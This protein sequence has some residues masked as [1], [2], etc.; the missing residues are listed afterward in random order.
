MSMSNTSGIRDTTRTPL[1]GQVAIVTGCG[2][3]D[4]IGFAVARLLNSLGARLV[5][6][7]RPSPNS[8]EE[9][10]GVEGLAEKLDG[11]EGKALA[12]RASVTDEA[13]CAGLVSQAIA[14]FGRI[15]ILVNNAGADHGGDRLP[16]A[17]V[18]LADWQRV[19]NVNLTGTFLMCRAVATPMAA[20]NYGR[21]VNIA[22]LA[23][24]R[25]SAHRAAYGASKAGVVGLTLS[26]AI[27]LAAQGI[28]VN[29]VCPGPIA[30]ARARSTALK[31]AKGGD[32]EAA[33]KER[34]GQIPVKRFGQVEDVANTVAYFANPAASFITGQAL[35]IDGGIGARLG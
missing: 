20:Q 4:G 19:L 2:K 25:G 21:I 14:R 6:S 27:E 18:S 33:L 15:D 26:L 9:G 34:A 17:Q 32:I 24:L 29:A 11:V 16:I 28:T 13:D 8:H 3:S 10:P 12:I 35:A 31:N 23:A 7:D 22:S 30:T 5:V 1:A